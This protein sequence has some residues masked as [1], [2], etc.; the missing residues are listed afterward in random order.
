M[1]K[2]SDKAIIESWRKNV[3]PWVSAIKNDEI[4]SRVEVTNHAI[5]EAIFSY[6]PSNLLDV[7]CGEGWLIREA[8]NAGIVCTGIDVV[9]E[10]YED[11][12]NSGGKFKLLPYEEFGPEAFDEA[13]DVIVCNFSLLGK[14][15]VEHVIQ[16]SADVLNSHGVLI[17]QTVH[18]VEASSPDN[19][20]DGWRKGSWQEF[21]E[22]FVDPPPWY[23]R[24]I[25]SWNA[26]FRLAGFDSL[27][28]TEPSHPE[29]GARMSVIFEARRGS[30]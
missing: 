26:L 30:Q 14:E 18:P 15:S 28:V 27:K 11:V 17:V 25:D 22:D 23:F 4:N 1:G 21:G 19:Y 13:F 24:T 6:E 10:F 20:V 2:F 16:Q 8:S 7:G 9:P 5:L 3:A 29:T 12:E